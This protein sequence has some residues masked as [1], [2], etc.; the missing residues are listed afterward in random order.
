MVGGEKRQFDFVVVA[1]S[2]GVSVAGFFNNFKSEMQEVRLLV[3]CGENH[4]I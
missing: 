2:R 4:I 1:S 3:M